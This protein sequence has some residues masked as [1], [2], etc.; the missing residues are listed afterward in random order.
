MHMSKRPVVAITPSSISGDAIRLLLKS[1]FP[2][3]KF[4][5]ID[6]FNGKEFEEITKKEIVTNFKFIIVGVETKSLGKI[7]APIRFNPCHLV[8]L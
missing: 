7:Y 3:D 5:R 4:E 8:A 1:V 6:F 2:D